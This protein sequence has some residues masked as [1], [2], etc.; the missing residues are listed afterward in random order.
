[1][2]SDI[3]MVIVGTG[4]IG[5]SMAAAISNVPGL[6]VSGI[7]SRDGDRAR[8][9]AHSLG[10][11]RSYDALV[12]VLA[13]ANVDAIY[14]ANETAAHAATAIA[15]LSAGKAVLC[16]KPCAVDSIEAETIVSVARRTGRLF[17][18]AIA[19]PFIPAVRAAL[20]E[21]GSG[22]LGDVRHLT[23]EF[24][25]PTTRTSHPGCY[26]ASGGGVLLDRAIYAVA[27]ARLA[28]GPVSSVQ[29]HVVREADGIDIEASLLLGHAEGGC[30]QLSASLTSMLGNAM[31]I[32]CTKGAVKV[33]APLLA[34]EQLLVRQTAT[35]QRPVASTGIRKL[36]KE[37]SLVRRAGSLL[38]VPR[39]KHLS[40]GYSPYAHE[41]AHFRDLCLSGAIES[42]VLPMNLSLEVMRI[43]DA[44]R[45]ANR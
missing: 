13:D 23:V 24:G 10:I 2:A 17:M 1:M 30:S 37:N 7:C 35:P 5:Q 42:P 45:E 34:A 38:R 29:S 11:A 4:Y 32:S 19:T 15:A 43:L 28:L 3:R 9:I 26:A 18:E 33:R 31:T 21:A 14:I 6:H 27:L 20:D 36:L 39:S 40:Y 22:R 8:A 44:A 16:E 25:Y 41:L 12:D